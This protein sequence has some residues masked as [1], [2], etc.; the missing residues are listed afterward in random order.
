MFPLSRSSGAAHTAAGKIY[1]AG[2]EG[3]TL[4]T[5]ILRYIDDPEASARVA[6]KEITQRCN[7]PL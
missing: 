6:I 1:I 3:T 4:M 7:P 2:Q 5:R